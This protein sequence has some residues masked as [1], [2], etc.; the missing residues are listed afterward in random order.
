MKKQAVRKQTE[1]SPRRGSLARCSYDSIGL[2]LSD[3]K[4][5]VEYHDGNVGKAWVGVHLTNKLT[6]VGKRWTS[7]DPYVIEHINLPRTVDD[8]I[9]KSLSKYVAN[10]LA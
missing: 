9:I 10:K 2:I 7:Q 4:E 1:L 8:N 6:K 5:R 3:S